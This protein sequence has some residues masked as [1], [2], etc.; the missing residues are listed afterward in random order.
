MGGRRGASIRHSRVGTRFCL[1]MTLLNFWMKLLQKW[2]FRTKINEHYHRILHVQISLDS[3]FLLHQTI[4]IFGTNFQRKMY[5][6]SK[7]QKNEHHYW[8][9]HIRI[10]LNTNFQLKLTNAIFWTKFVKISSY[11]QSKTDKR[12]TTIELCIFK[13]VL[14]PNLSLN[15][16]FWLFWPDLPKKWLFWSKTEKGNTTYSPH[17][18]AYSN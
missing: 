5:F 3:K 12:D 13:L 10:S 6:Q 2:Y 11:F 1:E 8:F 15:W 18:S 4:F 17:I 9:L 14:V 16:Q 7:I